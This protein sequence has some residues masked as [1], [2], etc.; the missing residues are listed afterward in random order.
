VQR[1]LTTP[2]GVIPEHWPTNGT[3]NV[4]GLG[5]PNGY[6][7]GISDFGN[8]DSLV[9]NKISGT[10]YTAFYEPPSTLSL[11]TKIDTSGSVRVTAVSSNK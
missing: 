7:A 10:G 1:P 11:Y 9:N 3:S 5:F 4:S 6:Q 8:H 2:S